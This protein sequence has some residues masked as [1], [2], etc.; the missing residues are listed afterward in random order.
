[1]TGIPD[2][3]LL[4]VV[5]NGRVVGDIQRTGS[6]KMR[7]RYGDGMS[8][9]ST[10]L[11]VSMTGPSGRF[12]ES[13]LV[14]WLDGLLPDRPETVRQWRRQFGIRNDDSTF[15]LL[16]FI[17]EDV[18]GAAQF[19]RPERLNAVL[20]QAGSVEAVSSI[21]IADMLRRAQMDIPVTALPGPEGKFSLAGA[22]SKIALHRMDE[23]WA[24]PSGAIPSTHIVKPAIPGMQDQDL[25][26]AV[27][28]RAA[29][30]LGLSAARTSIADFG[31]VRALVVSRYDRVQQD[32]GKW[33]RVHQ[34]DMCQALGVPPFRKYENQGG[35]PAA[36][37]ADL[38]GNVSSEAQEDN[39]H[40]AQALI[41]NWLVCGT[42]AHARNY[43]LLLSGSS[44]RL[45][46]LY[47]LNSHLAYTDGASSE[48]SMSIGG[49]FRAA[50][51][52]PDD[53]AR[54]AG[55]LH[56]DSEWIG[57]EVAR[58]A[59]LLPA[60]LREAASSADI[61]RYDSAVIARLLDSANNWLSRWF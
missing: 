26:E 58:Q 49:R 37:V 20:G 8:A 60:A 36:L 48:L 46:P 35:P 57:A 7:L 21:R 17:G 42:D 22:Q 10:P 24:N 27:T 2:D 13:V 30:T 4:H 43:S 32:G 45:A 5:M 61:A 50:R 11:S 14:P 53:W 55:V 31:D 59:R 12:R 44:V 16:R 23:G 47:D 6:R 9:R 29:R 51:I 34:E 39:R 52:T 40:F 54:H 1:M 38:I 56:V 15:A 28:M 18:A 33:I 3:R 19:L 41:F 25:V